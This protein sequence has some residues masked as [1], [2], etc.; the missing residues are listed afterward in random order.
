MEQLELPP[1]HAE[2]SRPAPL[3]RHVSDR[4]GLQ[5]DAPSPR[6]PRTAQAS[7]RSGGGPASP[8]RS[9]SGQKVEPTGMTQYSQVDPAV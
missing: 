5:P 2:A 3:H 7:F 1:E 9:G 8:A 4:G 6:S